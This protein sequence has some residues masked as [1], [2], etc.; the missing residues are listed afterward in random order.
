ML[1]AIAHGKPVVAV[2]IAQADY[3][4]PPNLMRLA[5]AEAA[6]H[7][8]SYLSWPT[9]PQESRKTMIE[10]VRPQAV[11]LRQNSQI[12]NDAQRVTDAVVFLPFDRYLET[13]DC[14]ALSVVRALSAANLQ[15]DV[16]NE[17]ALE[18]HLAKPPPALIVESPQVL[19]E[20]QRA[21]VEKYQ[22]SGGHVIWSTDAKWLGQLKSLLTPR[23]ITVDAP[24]TVRAVVRRQGERTIV[25][26]LNLNV[27]RVSSFEDQVTPATQVRIKV[28]CGKV[29][30]TKVRLRTPDDHA[31]RGAVPL[32]AS[33][34]G[35]E[36]VADL[37][38]PRLDIS[39][40]V[41]IE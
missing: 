1:H 4:T 16:V 22:A 11:F 13:P 23:A 37:T 35:G 5:M 6:A 33:V 30:P 14:R 32:G 38:V 10:A 36:F 15:F 17:E 20:A 21:C 31:T 29:Q 9:W 2:T 41:V 40:I 8:A 3:H 12:L 19:T 28:R 7:G 39:T 18:A 27:R 24:P 34:D 25:H 26:L